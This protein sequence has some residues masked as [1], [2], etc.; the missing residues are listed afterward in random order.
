LV[1]D[2]VK[3]NLAG[4]VLFLRGTFVICGLPSPA[5]AEGR[6][7]LRVSLQDLRVKCVAVRL[8][9]CFTPLSVVRQ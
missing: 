7:R 9:V 5:W 2:M 3:W 8:I 1:D 4:M 6:Q